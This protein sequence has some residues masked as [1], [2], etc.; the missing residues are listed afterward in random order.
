MAF[1]RDDLKGFY[2]RLVKKAM[3]NPIFDIDR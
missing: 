3:F 1:P 2:L